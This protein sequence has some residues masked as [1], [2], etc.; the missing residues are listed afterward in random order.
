METRIRPRDAQVTA[1]A[2]PSALSA[3]P[4]P[5]TTADEVEERIVLAI[6]LGEKSPGDRITEAELAATLN[7][8]RMPAREALQKLHLRGVLVESDQRGLKVADYSEAFIDDLYE[9]RHSIERVVLRRVMSENFDRSELLEELEE[10]ISM[11]RDLAGSDDTL[12]LGK[13]DLAFHRAI[14]RHSGNE[15][16]AKIWEG[17]AQHCLIVFLRDWARV[18]DRTSEVALHRHFADFIA[19]GELEDIDGLLREHYTPAHDRD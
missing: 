19:N 13:T 7:V 8:S 2:R 18:A 1:S 6:A 17:L 15:L 14:L 4:R 16:A 9:V 10:H 12:L 3:I 11:M 5:R